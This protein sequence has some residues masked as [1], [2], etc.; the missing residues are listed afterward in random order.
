VKILRVTKSPKEQ[1]E[2]IQEE[3][4]I[5]KRLNWIRQNYNDETIDEYSKYWDEYV[6]NYE[7]VMSEYYFQETGNRDIDYER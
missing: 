4:R 2:D 3:E 7:E 1:L 6:E 5:E